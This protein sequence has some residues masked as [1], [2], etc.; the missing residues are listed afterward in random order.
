LLKISKFHQLHQIFFEKHN[1]DLDTNKTFDGEALFKDYPTAEKSFGGVT[2]ST[3]NIARK[4]NRLV[5]SSGSQQERPGVDNRR[6][7]E[8]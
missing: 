7:S 6:Q 8:H 2:F 5:I 1:I 4:R 3:T